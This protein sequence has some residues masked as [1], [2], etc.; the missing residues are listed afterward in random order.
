ME[1]PPT[2]ELSA[3]GQSAGEPTL[4][5]QLEVDKVVVYDEVELSAGEE[6]IDSD[7]VE[8]DIDL[9][10]LDP[11]LHG[12]SKHRWDIATMTVKEALVSWK[13]KAV[14]AAMDEEIRSLITNGTWEL[15]KRP[16]GV[17]VMKNRWVLMP[18]HVDDTVAREKAR[19]V[20][21]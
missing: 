3:R 2:G 19:L 9:P 15:V 5:R 13:G 14:K 1:M 21:K 12:D 17:N 16:R 7:A 4:V 10:E 18:N 8:A 6:S 11:N 20:M